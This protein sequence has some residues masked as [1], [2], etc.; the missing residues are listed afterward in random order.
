MLPEAI[1]GIYTETILAIENEQD[2]LAGIGIRAIVETICKDRKATGQT[3]F[4]QIDALKT[5]SI[6]TPDGA[7]I[8]H[9]LRVLGNS[10]AHE[11]K[12]HNSAQLSLAIK[13]IRH[14]LEGTY[15]IPVQVQRAFPAP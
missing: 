3:L 2:I 5:Q 14:M 8:L 1:Q 11:V 6:V 9:K 4:Q 12:A 13:I 10:A 7:E 15:I